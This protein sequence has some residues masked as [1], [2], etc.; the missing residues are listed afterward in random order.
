[1]PAPAKPAKIVSLIASATEI[2]CALGARDRLVGRSHECDYPPDILELPQLT[3]PKFPVEGSS[4]EIDKRVK[5]VVEEGLSVYR[6]DADALESLSP[7]IIVTQDHCEVCAVSLSDVEDAVCAWSG[8]NAEIVSLHPGSLADIW[9]DIA[10]VASALG[11]PEAGET[12]IAR[13]MARMETIA[14]EARKAKSKPSIAMIEW[15]DPMMGGGNWMPELVEMAGAT[16]FLAKPGEPSP[17]VEWDDIL[18]EDP[19]IVFV[20]PCGFDIPRTLQEMPILEAK[21]GWQDLKAVRD[22]KI[23]VADGNQYF[24]RPGPRVVESLEILA[25]IAHP[26]LF[27]PRFEGTGWIRYAGTSS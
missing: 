7:D 6:V 2:V 12:L 10:K 20:H 9:A 15:I 17:W 18:K 27:P 1:M 5:A 4:S 13:S 14:A 3:E 8:R 26:D 21:P 24:N 11:D 19:D 22:G 23:F 16:D 25:E